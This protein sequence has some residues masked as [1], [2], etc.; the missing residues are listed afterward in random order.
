MVR[1]YWAAI[2][3]GDRDGYLATF[4]DDAVVQDPVGDPPLYSRE[5]RCKFIENLF[6]KLTKRNF[7]VDFLTAAGD[8]TAAKWT[9]VAHSE[10]GSVHMEG[11]DTFR[12][13]ADGRID[14]LWAYPGPPTTAPPAAAS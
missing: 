5:A 12:H 10:A 7:T 3:A 14:R 9:L 11:I 6:H 13:G 8:A 2:N 1:R 4:A